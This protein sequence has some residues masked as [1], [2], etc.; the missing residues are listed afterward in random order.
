MTDSKSIVERITNAVLQEIEEKT[1]LETEQILQVHQISYYNSKPV[2]ERIDMEKGQDI[3]AYCPIVGEQ[4]YLALCF[5][6]VADYSLKWVSTEANYSVYFC[7]ATKEDIKAEKITSLS[8]LNPSQSWSKGDELIP[9]VKSPTTKVLYEP[10]PEPDEFQ[11]K[12]LKLLT[13]LEQDEAG[14]QNIVNQYGGVIEVK[15]MFHNGNTMLGNISLNSNMM[16]RLSAL[17]INIDFDIYAEGN[18]FRQDDI[19]E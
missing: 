2:I 15:A 12:L 5:D 14:I 7:V 19:F 6:M 4:F 10:N 16:K 9:S 17:N 13:Y 11:D 3:I 1:F 8:K 18:M